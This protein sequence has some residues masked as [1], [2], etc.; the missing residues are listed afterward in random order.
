M[1]GEPR[2]AARTGPNRGLYPGDAMAFFLD[3][4]RAG[5]RGEKT[6]DDYR[7]KLDLFQRWLARRMDPEEVDAPY[8]AADADARRARR[9]GRLRGV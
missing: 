6:L 8:A 1:N 3:A 4:K 2:V 9:G 5:G 7:K